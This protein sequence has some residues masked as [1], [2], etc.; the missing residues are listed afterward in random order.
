MPL[1]ITERLGVNDQHLQDQMEAA[2]SMIMELEGLDRSE[3]TAVSAAIVHHALVVYT[4]LY[5]LRVILKLKTDKLSEIDS[6][7]DRLAARLR[8]HG[9]DV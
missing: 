4:E 6:L 1:L 2:N 9:E 5:R 8:E 3:S 7:V